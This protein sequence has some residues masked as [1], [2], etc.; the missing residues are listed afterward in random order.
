M[1]LTQLYAAA[2][3]S[4]LALPSTVLADVTALQVWNDFQ[5]LMARTGAQVSFE[6]SIS[7]GILT[8]NNLNFTTK[9]G[10]TDVVTLIKI[11]SL[12]FQDQDDGSVVVLLPTDAPIVVSNGKDLITINQSHKNL[13][14]I[15][16][17]A[18]KDLT[19]SYKA[20][21]L[22]LTLVDLVVAGEKIDN[23]AADIT[24][25]AIT[26]TT[27]SR[28]TGL[29]EMTQ[30]V[31]IGVVS[32]RLDY[33]SVDE[34]TTLSSNG[35]LTDVKSHFDVAIPENLKTGTMQEVLEAGFKAIGHFGYS[36]ITAS[37]AMTQRG[38]VTN[39][40]LSTEHGGMNLRFGRGEENFLEMSQNISFGPSKAHVNIDIEGKDKKLMFGLS[41]AQIGTGYTVNFPDA[42]KQGNFEDLSF[43]E[44]LDAGLAI[45][46]GF[47]YDG[48]NGAL[49]GNDGDK[50][51]VGN[52]TSATAGIDLFLGRNVFR[53]TGDV[54]ATELSLTA[55]ELPIGPIEFSVSEI[56]S[57]YVVPLRVSNEPT[58]FTYHDRIINMSISDNL[59]AMFDPD[60]ILPHGPLT[61]V[62]DI[63]GMGNW[64]IDPFGKKF[65]D[66]NPDEP[67][68]ELHSLSLNDLQLSVAGIDLTGAGA[69]TF[70]NDDMETFDGIPAPTGEIN[71][72]MSGANALLDKLLEIGLL[73]EDEAMGARMALGLIAVAGEGENVLTSHIVISEDG[74]V[75]ANGQRL[76]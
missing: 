53:Y 46:F 54:G 72:T 20:T 29:Q 42:F 68:G 9:E 64:L 59:W 1:R 26:G 49:S 18:P 45:K 10:G 44:A 38:D 23:I 33:N 61:Y 27:H 14:L 11:G 66:D 39:A 32:Y 51:Y 58:Q 67:K 7:D 25:S 56:G 62:L 6:Q 8:V 19:Y 34:D 21:K 4:I 5:S 70:N 69:F 65:Q 15:V 31:A 74:K 24:L 35:S 16:S 13:S 40:T 73:T 36:D 41:I 2:A 47:G 37:F 22:S 52:A 12:M 71:L 60:K 3:L 43:P 17:G 28:D 63:S 55:Q 48:I 50:S 30:D 75:L 57:N 76:K